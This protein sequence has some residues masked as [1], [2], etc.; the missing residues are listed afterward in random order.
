MREVCEEVAGEAGEEAGGE[1]GCSMQVD[2]SDALCEQE[3]VKFTV[4]TRVRGGGE[5]SGGKFTVVRSHEDFL[6]L[7]SVVEEDPSY[8]GLIIPPRPPR[9]D[10]QVSAER[11]SRLGE[12]EARGGRVEFARVK[13][14]L[15]A[16]Y[17]AAFKKTVAQ[18]EGFLQRLASHPTLRMDQNLLVF[19]EYEEEL[20]VRGKNVKEKLSEFLGQ[21]QRSGDELLLASTQHDGDSFFETEKVRLMTTHS[22]LRTACIAADKLCSAHK[23][24]ANSCSHVAGRLAELVMAGPGLAALAPVCEGLEKVKRLE[25]RLANDQELKLA[26]TLR[27]HVRDTGAAKDLLYRRLRA[28]ANFEASNKELDLA[29]S[30]NRDRQLAEGIQREAWAALEHLTEGARAELELQRSRRVESLQRNLRELAELEVKHAR[31]HCQA[32]REALRAVR[33]GE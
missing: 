6:W 5:E 12:R 7:H 17:L 29:R 16:D 20:G 13:Q 27:Y 31:S 33:A 19:L 22:R 4:Q 3:R 26:D 15:E 8:A 14:D 25:G 32:L 18:H 9:P 28:L 21:F 1:D 10:F 11:L 30:K 23:G 24:L 2:I